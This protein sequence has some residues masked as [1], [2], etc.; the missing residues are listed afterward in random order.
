MGNKVYYYNKGGRVYSWLRIF[1]SSH[2][3][4]S[5]SSS[6]GAFIIINKES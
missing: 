5:E 3:N 4:S 2:D 6:Q 1:L